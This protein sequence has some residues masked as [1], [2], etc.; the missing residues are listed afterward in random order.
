MGSRLAAGPARAVN[1]HRQDE[2]RRVGDDMAL[3]P[4]DEFAPVEATPWP[5]DAARLD[6]LAID[7]R[8][9]RARLASFLDASGPTQRIVEAFDQAGGHPPAEV[10]VDGLPGREAAAAP[11]KHP[12]RAA[13]P[14]EVE[15]GVHEVLGVV[16]AEGLPL[17]ERFDMLPLGVCQVRVVHGSGKSC[18]SS[19]STRH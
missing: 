2:P 5:T 16:L 12:P 1:H 9:R 11:G 7:D 18:E 4:L 10:V 13:G 14:G 17:E 15:R 19:Y 6:R 3:T 8:R